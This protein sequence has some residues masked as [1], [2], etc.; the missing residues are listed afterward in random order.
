MS[1]LVLLFLDISL[2]R[3]RWVPSVV[4][5]PSINAK[6]ARPVNNPKFV[7]P[8]RCANIIK[9]PACRARRV[10][11]TSVVD[12]VDLAVVLRKAWLIYVRNF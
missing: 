8:S 7:A 10:P 4:S 2:S 3:T 9:V 11:K 1:D 5:E 6:P 12:N